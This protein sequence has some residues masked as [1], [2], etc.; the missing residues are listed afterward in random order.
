MQG[1]IKERAFGVIL[2]NA[3]P[4]SMNDDHVKSK[5]PLWIR[6]AEVIQLRQAV[7][8]AQSA[9]TPGRHLSASK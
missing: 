5:R 7:L 8:E 3:P 4:A 6:Y 1:C 9:K 2:S